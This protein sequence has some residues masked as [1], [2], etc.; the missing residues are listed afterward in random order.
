VDFVAGLHAVASEESNL[1]GRNHA[2]L[3]M[4]DLADVVLFC[5]GNLFPAHVLLRALLKLLNL[6][7]VDA[8]KGAQGA[9]FQI[10][11]AVDVHAALF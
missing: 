7:Q 6:G 5:R 8:P 1:V 11:A 10:P 9:L 2:T 4:R 3:V